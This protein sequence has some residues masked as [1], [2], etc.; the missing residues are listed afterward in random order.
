MFFLKNPVPMYLS[1]REGYDGACMV[2]ISYTF[3]SLVLSNSIS[4]VI[5]CQYYHIEVKLVRLDFS[6][7]KDLK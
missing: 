2:P 1:S 4:E 3:E 5:Y 7:I 6:A